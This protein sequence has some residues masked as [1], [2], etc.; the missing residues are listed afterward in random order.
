MCLVILMSHIEWASENFECVVF[1]ISTQKVRSGSVLTTSWWNG[2]SHETE[3]IPLVCT[4][5]VKLD[6]GSGIPIRIKI[7]LNISFIKLYRVRKL[8]PWF[9]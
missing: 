2:A 6:T 9:Q 8:F 4:V 7:Y 3:T 1:Q 5:E